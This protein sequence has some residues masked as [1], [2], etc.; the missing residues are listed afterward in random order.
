[1]ELILFDSYRKYQKENN[2][3]TI[4]N[5]KRLPKLAIFLLLVTVACM[6]ASIVL[7]FVKIIPDAV[8]LLVICGE[9]ILY[10]GLF[11]YTENYQIEIAN[12]RLG[13]YRSYCIE[14]RDWLESTGFVVN[15][16]SI[17][18]LKERILKQVAEKKADRDRL[19]N[20][21][22]HAFDIIVVPLLLAIFAN[23][24]QNEQD[25]NAMFISALTLISGLGT[26]I[27]IVYV[28]YS[29]IS[30]YNKRKLELLKCFANDLQGIMD[31]QFDK[32]LLTFSEN[33][34]ENGG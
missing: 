18:T 13:N 9:Y 34:T 6:V 2:K 14:L 15:S 27:M 20:I 30:F 26:L 5:L 11:F 22:K 17:M 24:I 19:N 1:M 23:I 25:I 32:K 21:I 7:L 29:V 33:P 3:F 10:V 16:Q 28:I 31:T 4:R 8:R 12:T